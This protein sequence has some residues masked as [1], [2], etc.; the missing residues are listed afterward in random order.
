MRV[1]DKRKPI[2]Y[3]KQNASAR[4]SGFTLIEILIVIAIIALLAAILFPVFARVRE[5]ARRTSCA[6]NLKQIGTAVQ[7]YIQDNDEHLPTA[8]SDSST[9]GDIVGIL[10][11]Y[12]KQQYGQGIWKCPSHTSF[13]SDGSWTSSYG[14]NWQYLLAQGPNPTDPY[15]HTD[16]SSYEGFY[17]PGVVLSFL[18]R[19]A[20]TLC[21]IDQ[22]PVAGKL[23]TYVNRPGD[24]LGD[25]SD[26]FGRPDFRHNS[27]ANVLFCDGHVKAVPSSFADPVNEAKFW[28]PR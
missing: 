11:P 1:K 3:S 7:M 23:W 12:T 20:E 24:P 16:D 22:K 18:A 15:P 6:S 19:P 28:D 10:T 4:R 25:D 26:G 13:P 9:G 27:R 17:N 8:G 5:N 2:A 14:Y 21:F